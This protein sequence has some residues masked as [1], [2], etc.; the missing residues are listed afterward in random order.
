VTRRLTALAGS[1]V[2]SS[3]KRRPSEGRWFALPDDACTLLDGEDALLTGRIDGFFPTQRPGSRSLI[4]RG[5][6]AAADL[7]DCSPDSI[8][9]ITNVSLTGIAET[10]AAPF[11]VPVTAAVDVGAR[12]ASF[13]LHPGETCWTALAR[14][15]RARGVLAVSD[16]RGGIVLTRAGSARCATAIDESANGTV[17]LGRFSRIGR[18]GKIRVVGMDDRGIAIGH[19]ATDSGVSASRFKRIDAPECRTLAACAARARWEVRT[20]AAR[21]RT[22]SVQVPGWR[23]AD[24]TLWP[25]NALVQGRVPSDGIDG[26]LLIAGVSF[27]IGPVPGGEGRGER[28]VLELVPPEAF[29]APDSDDAGVP[30]ILE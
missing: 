11:D 2:L 15:C 27:L 29:A 3:A 26:D 5:R 14:A 30:E 18:F 17:V 25:L 19:E 23:Q 8:A 16:A 28:T 4:V 21:A 10:L 9:P 12:F 1:F 20:R 7:V 24:G 6:D 22:L 13:A